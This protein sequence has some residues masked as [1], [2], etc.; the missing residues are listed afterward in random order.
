MNRNVPAQASR[1]DA[2]TPFTVAG[3]QEAQRLLASKAVVSRKVFDAMLPEVRARLFTVGLIETMD[4]IQRVRD[5]IADVPMGEDWTKT[6]K[7]LAQEFSPYFD[8]PA[9]AS[10]RA[11]LVL[12]TNAYDAYDASQTRALN[13]QKDVMP[14]LQW[15]T[16]GD[17]RVRD[18]HAALDGKVFPADSPF[19][20]RGKE[21]GCRC[22]RTAHTKGD[23]DEMKAADADKDPGDRRVLEGQALRDAENGFLTVGPRTAADLDARQLEWGEQAGEPQSQIVDLNKGS[24]PR[25]T[26]LNDAGL[27][28]DPQSLRGKYD[29]AT[30]ALFENTARNVTVD[31]KTS[32]LDWLSGKEPEI[33]EMAAPFPWSRR[34]ASSTAGVDAE[35]PPTTK[36]ER[37]LRN[38]EAANVGKPVEHALS[39]TPD[40]RVI[41]K[42][43]GS[44]SGVK[45]AVEPGCLVTHTHAHEGPP[46]IDEDIIALL[47]GDLGASRIATGDYI[48]IFERPVGGWMPAGSKV[49]EVHAQIKSAF[50]EQL[51]VAHDKLA[52]EIKPG[53]LDAWNRTLDE[54]YHLAYAEVAKQLGWGYRRYR[55]S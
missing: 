19:W 12:R 10:A 24:R 31:G 47:T 4:G 37:A 33:V 1:E 21:W 3:D 17:E 49:K 34:N 15:H 50:F 52:R 8:D 43:A 55:R 7:A 27:R 29:P 30:W 22:Y 6:R 25:S 46:T 20:E 53:D 48:Y 16:A 32:L 54:S 11:E 35:P 36:A 28:I 2:T 18:S 14:Y 45:V 9:A 5:M 44:G 38:F 26:P 41:D 40:G 23:V 13:E 51:S 42:A 39:V